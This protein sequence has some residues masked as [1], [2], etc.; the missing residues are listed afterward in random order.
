MVSIFL[1]HTVENR[2]LCSLPLLLLMNYSIYI[3]IYNG[4]NLFEENK[5]QFGLGG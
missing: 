1:R 3:Y 2:L 4:V 5:I